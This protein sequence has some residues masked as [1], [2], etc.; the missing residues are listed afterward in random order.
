[1]IK[2]VIGKIIKSSEKQLFNNKPILVTGS[3]RSGTTW[4][5]KVLD[6]SNN[7]CYLS[8]PTN[9]DNKDS[10][11]NINYRFQ[12]IRNHDKTII[13][14]LQQ[15]DKEVLTLQK[16]ALFK[17]PLAFFSI[18]AFI[19]HLDADVLISVRHP[20][21]FTSSLKRLGWSHTFDHFLAQEELMNTYLYPF[22]DEIKDFAKNDKDVIDQG[23]LLWNMIYLNVLKFK[24]KYPQIYVIRHEDLSLNPINEFQKIFDYFDLSFTEDTKQYLFDT[25]NEGNSAEAQNNVLHQLNRNSKENIYNFKNRLTQEEIARIKKGTQNVSHV[26]YGQEWWDD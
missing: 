6:Q 10:I 17:D 8:E 14:D 7:L 18:D 4:I 22:R 9:Y 11:A 1:M 20:A 2:K 19:N 21:A 26:F 3:H 5:G 12:Y 24:Q 25:T 13:R 15:L 23:I 16:R